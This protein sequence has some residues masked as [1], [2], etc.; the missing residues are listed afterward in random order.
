MQHSGR[1]IL[2]SA[3]RVQHLLAQARRCSFTPEHERRLT[4]LQ[5]QVD[6]LRDV[7]H[8]VVAL[9]REQADA[10]LAD[11]G[12]QLEAALAALTPPRDPRASLH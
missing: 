9:L 12:H 2:Y 4:A 1:R 8:L 11:L 10:E 7:L 5:E 6:E 3:E